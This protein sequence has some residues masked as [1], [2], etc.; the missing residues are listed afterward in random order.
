MPSNHTK[1]H[2]YQ[3]CTSPVSPRN[4]SHITAASSPLD[5]ASSAGD[6]SYRDSSGST[7]ADMN[8]VEPRA[9]GPQKKP[10]NRDSSSITAASSPLDENSFAGDC[11]LRES[12]GS[13]P[14]MNLVQPRA[15]SLGE[16]FA[17]RTIVM[18]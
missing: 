17:V 2:E 16:A 12:S 14:H 11:S 10:T 6:C 18:M 7:L 5:E 8:L 13:T 15:E 9:A 4:T 3:S 1:E